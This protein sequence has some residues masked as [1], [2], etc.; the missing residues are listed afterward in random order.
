MTLNN[1]PSHLDKNF[2][3]KNWLNTLYNLSHCDK[4]SIVQNWLIT[5]TVSLW[6]LLWTWGRFLLSVISQL[7]IIKL[8]SKWDALLLRVTW[9]G[10]LHYISCMQSLCILLPLWNYDVKIWETWLRW[11]KRVKLEILMR[12]IAK[13]HLKKCDNNPS[14]IIHLII[15]HVLKHAFWKTLVLTHIK[16]FNH[17]EKCDRNPSH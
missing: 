10:L 12:H 7:C 1:N 4:S 6:E 15:T 9:F 17:L 5:I 8:L 13:I 16:R 11:M 2:I 3:I 14:R